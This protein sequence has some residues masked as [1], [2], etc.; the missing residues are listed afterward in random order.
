M[1]ISVR[2]AILFILLSSVQVFSQNYLPLFSGYM[3]ESIMK[4]EDFKN[5][6]N[7]NIGHYASVNPDLVYYYIMYID[8]RFGEK[9]TNPDSN[10]YNLLR[11]EDYKFRN[12]T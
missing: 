5:Q 10:Y 6:V 2:T 7:I 3:P 1:T 11:S 4:D 9:I 12:S 8:K